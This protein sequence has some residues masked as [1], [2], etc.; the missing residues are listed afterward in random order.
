VATNYPSSL[1]AFTTRASQGVIASSHV[2]DLQDAVTAIETELG[3]APK[4]AA[5]SVK[6]R[7]VADEARIT[8]L[9][10]AGAIGTALVSGAYYVVSPTT[11]TNTQV[12]GQPYLLPYFFISA[13]T[14][15]TLSVEVSASGAT[16]TLA[17]G[18]Y[19]DSSGRPGALLA[20]GSVA[21]TS[22]GIKTVTLGSPVACSARTT[23]WFGALAT[24]GAAPT[25][26]TAQAPTDFVVPFNA[27]PVAAT[28]LT[29]VTTLA[30]GLSALPDPA[31][32]ITGATSRMPRIIFHTV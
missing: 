12:L 10:G 4:G 28:G 13:V 7:L 26:F 24:G 2:N 31:S 29:G 8:A 21:T 3:T 17:L 25:C 20:S 27:I 1:D 32:T 19:A 11:S 23:Y 5:A 18:I 9:E 14:V 30:A 16:S 6:A 15:D 22:T